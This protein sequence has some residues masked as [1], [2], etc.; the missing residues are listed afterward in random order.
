MYKCVC[1]ANKIFL[2]VEKY[3]VQKNLTWICC[4]AFCFCHTCDE[5]SERYYVNKQD[6]AAQIL[7][8]FFAQSAPDL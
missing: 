8:L 6:A 1:I 4:E 7:E 2:V 5:F 3:N